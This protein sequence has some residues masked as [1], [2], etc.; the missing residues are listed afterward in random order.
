MAKK[1]D[2]QTDREYYG[3]KEYINNIED[4]KEEDTAPKYSVDFD[5][6]WDHKNEKIILKAKDKISKRRWQLTLGKESYLSPSKEYDRMNEIFDDDD[7]QL[8]TQYN[9]IDGD[10]TVMFLKQKA[11]VETYKFVLPQTQ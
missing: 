2:T 4:K 3:K 9:Q 8:I 10:L 11:K 6:E 1:S 5:W 7:Y